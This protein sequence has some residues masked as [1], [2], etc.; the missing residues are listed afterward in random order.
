MKLLWTAMLML[1]VAG[2]Y[3][4]LIR[5]QLRTVPQLAAAYRTADGFW[6]RV[7]LWF[8]KS[9]AVVLG[10]LGTFFLEAMD[11]LPGIVSGLTGVDFGAFVDPEIA[12]R[13]SQALLLAGVFLRVRAKSPIGS[14]EDAR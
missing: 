8:G 7:F 9:R 4:G 1:A 2:I 3:F 5:P 10:V 11:V 12:K 6:E 13:I 14:Q